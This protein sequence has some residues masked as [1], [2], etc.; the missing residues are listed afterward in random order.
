M[1]VCG[2]CEQA[3]LESCFYKNR[4]KSDGLQAYCK[5]CEKGR[6]KIFIGKKFNCTDCGTEFTINHR[7][8]KKRKTFLCEECLGKRIVQINKNRSSKEGINST[9][10]YKYDRDGSTKHGYSFRHRN[11][12]SNFLNRPLL[13]TEV[14]HHI[15]GNRRNNEIS[16]LFLTDAKGHAKAHRSLTILAFQLYEAGNIYFDISEG[17]YKI[18]K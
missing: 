6:G 13:P 7:N 1:K 17:C 9:R 3:K 15:D 11:I 14:V 2:S 12:L 10:G 16:N 8:I 18:V 4:T 5:D